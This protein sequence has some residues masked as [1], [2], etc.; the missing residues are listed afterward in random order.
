MGDNLNDT[1]EELKQFPFTS[2]YPDYYPHMTIAYLKPGKGN[3]Y[4]NMLGD[5]HNEMIMTPQ[6]AVYSR[7][8][9]AKH[10]IPVRLQ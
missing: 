5:E 4:I 3:D 9:G 7:T 6:Y 8:D 2:D 10:K 1:N